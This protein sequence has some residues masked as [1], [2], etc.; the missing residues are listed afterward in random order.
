MLPIQ[1]NLTAI[2]VPESSLMVLTHLRDF[3]KMKDGQWDI[4]FS[5]GSSLFFETMGRESGICR[6]L[7]N[8]WLT[9]DDRGMW[10]G[11]YFKLTPTTGPLAAF[12]PF[13]AEL[14]SPLRLRRMVSG[15]N[16]SIMNQCFS[17][18]TGTADKTARWLQRRH[19]VHVNRG[20]FDD[21]SHYPANENMISSLTIYLS[22]RF[23][24]APREYRIGLDTRGRT[25]FA[26]KFDHTAGIIVHP[27]GVTP[28]ITFFDPNYGQFT[29]KE[30][31]VSGF[32]GWL[33][34][35]YAYS[36]GN[37]L[38]EWR[39]RTYRRS[40]EYMPT[41]RGKVTYDR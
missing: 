18:A 26:H 38:K 35:W 5:P 40:S 20:N 15:Q 33:P 28:R 16:V 19:L 39:V 27:R 36:Y 10:G 21:R 41:W 4:F 25:I 7:T 37:L 9:Q 12:A 17:P 23:E 24:R 11:K 3:A 29:F 32:L 2:T 14:V 1:S 6:E 22:D 31:G 30:F 8:K 34:Y 13:E